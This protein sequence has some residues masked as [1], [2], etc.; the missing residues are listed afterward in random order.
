[1]T[2]THEFK[3]GTSRGGITE[4]RNR[5]GAAVRFTA[6]AGCQSKDFKTFAGASRWLAKSGYQPAA[7]R[8]AENL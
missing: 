8:G 2:T 5:S 4:E 7:A 3:R 6:V 1:M